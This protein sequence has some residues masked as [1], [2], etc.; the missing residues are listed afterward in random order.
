MDEVLCGIR[1]IADGSTAETQHF[2][3]AGAP[4]VGDVLIH[5]NDSWTVYRV[6]WVIT[7][8]ARALR[9]PR[10]VNPKVILWVA[11]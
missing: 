8:T 6:H 3:L 5:E 7:D 2:W 10:D 1:K 4:R 9:E 11:R